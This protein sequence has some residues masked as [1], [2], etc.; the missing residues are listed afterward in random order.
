M[1]KD[2]LIS[3]MVFAELPETVGLPV[4]ERLRLGFR[5]T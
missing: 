3:H 2:R 5:K 4:E 1:M